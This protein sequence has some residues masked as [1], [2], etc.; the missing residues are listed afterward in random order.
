MAKDKN[1]IADFLKKLNI[2]VIRMGNRNIYYL[3]PKKK[4][5]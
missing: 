1:V 4:S 2:Y 3:A 5:K